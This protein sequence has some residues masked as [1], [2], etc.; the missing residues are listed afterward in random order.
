[1]EQLGGTRSFNLPVNRRQDHKLVAPLQLF[2]AP[3]VSAAH[4]LRT[5]GIDASLAE[6]N[7]EDQITQP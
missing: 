4:R 3:R 7:L 6:S 1:M 2:M 5:T